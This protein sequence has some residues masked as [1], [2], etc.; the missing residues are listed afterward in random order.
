VDIN[1]LLSDLQFKQLSLEQVSQLAPNSIQNLHIAESLP[2][3]FYPNYMEGHS[4]RQVLF[5]TSLKA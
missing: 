5:N 1:V 4:L 3:A 2:I